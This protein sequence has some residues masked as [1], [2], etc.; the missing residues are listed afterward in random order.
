MTKKKVNI[1]GM[2]TNRW[3]PFTEKEKKEFEK[4]IKEH[5]KEVEKRTGMSY[6]DWMQEIGNKIK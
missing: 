3:K 6:E 5:K 1:E 2:L 4:I